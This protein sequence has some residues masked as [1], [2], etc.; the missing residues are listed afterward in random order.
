MI[1]VAEGKDIGDECHS[2]GWTPMARCAVVQGRGGS[3]LVREHM[4]GDDGEDAG[5]DERCGGDKQRRSVRANDRDERSRGL[6]YVV[7][8]SPLVSEP[9]EASG[10][11]EEW[12]RDEKN[13]E[14]EVGPCCVPVNDLLRG[15]GGLELGGLNA[16]KEERSHEED[17][18]EEKSDFEGSEGAPEGLHGD[19]LHHKVK[20]CQMKFARREEGC[21]RA[22]CELYHHGL[23]MMCQ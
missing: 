10:E 6:A 4:H 23:L 3:W 22:G 1:R 18:G 5:R 8:A 20:I 21:E 7:V 17:G 12:Q 9:G 2:S 13:P 15:M 16:A 11:N 14:A 19:T